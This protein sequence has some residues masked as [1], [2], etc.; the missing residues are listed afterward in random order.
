VH[1]HGA[2]VPENSQDGEVAR[3]I[4]AAKEEARGQYLRR[5]IDGKREIRDGTGMKE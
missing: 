4:D 1:D 2:A 5:V 3:V